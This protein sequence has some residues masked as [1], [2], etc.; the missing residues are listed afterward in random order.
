MTSIISSGCR[1]VTNIYL[2]NEYHQLRIIVA[3]IPMT[4]LRLITATMSSFLCL[5]GW[6]MPLPPS[7]I[8][9]MCVQVIP[10]FIFL[11]SSLMKYLYTAEM[12]WTWKI[13]EDSALDIERSVT[14]FQFPKARVLAWVCSIND[15]RGV[16]GGNKGLS[17]EDWDYSRL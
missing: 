1:R 11:S 9:D 13:F 14:F 12:E 15:A 4:A 7:W 10:W 3:D 2:M 6:L 8:D 5:W 16:L 17:G